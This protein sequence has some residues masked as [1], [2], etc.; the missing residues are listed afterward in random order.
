MNLV[1]SVLPNFGS[2]RID[3][4]SAFLRL[5][6]F[7]RG[8]FRLPTYGLKPMTFL[9]RTYYVHGSVPRRQMCLGH[10]GPHGISPPEGLLP[11]LLESERPSVPEDCGF[12]QGYTLLLPCRWSGGLERPFVELSWVSLVP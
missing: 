7:L 9:S 11:C 6:I 10:H 1:S 4:R 12:H 2:G 5:D 3:R 8:A